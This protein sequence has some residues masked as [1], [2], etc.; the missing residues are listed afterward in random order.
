MIIVSRVVGGFRQANF[1]VGF[2][3]TPF[4]L[5]SSK[6]S[7]KKQ[8]AILAHIA[9]ELF[10]SLK[11]KSPLRVALVG[12]K[13]K[14][15]TVW[16]AYREGAIDKT[17]EK[18]ITL[19]LHQLPPVSDVSFTSTMDLFP[20][21]SYISATAHNAQI[22]STSY[23]TRYQKAFESGQVAP[24]ALPDYPS[25][26]AALN[27]N[28][29][30]IPDY[31]G[32]SEP[33]AI[34]R[35]LSKLI[36]DRQFKLQVLKDALDVVDADHPAKGS[37]EKFIAVEDGYLSAHLNMEYVFGE[38][39][40]KQ[41]IYHAL[42]AEGM[43]DFSVSM[44]KVALNRAAV[45][46]YN[47][48][49]LL[50]AP[51]KNAAEFNGIFQPMGLAIVGGRLLT[52]ELYEKEFSNEE[53]QAAIHSLLIRCNSLQWVDS[54]AMT[55]Y[56][57][58]VIEK[59]LDQAFKAASA[60]MDQDCPF[61]INVSSPPGWF[62]GWEQP[63][64]SFNS[65]VKNSRAY[66]TDGDV[67]ALNGL[68]DILSLSSDKAE[69]EKPW[70]PRINEVIASISSLHSKEDALNLPEPPASPFSVMSSVSSSNN[71][72]ASTSTIL[73]EASRNPSLNHSMDDL[74]STKIKGS[75]MK[76]S[77]EMDGKGADDESLASEQPI[78]GAAS[79][80]SSEAPPPPRPKRR[81]R[82]VA[83]IL[84]PSSSQ[85]GQVQ[86]AIANDPQ[87]VMDDAVIENLTEK[88]CHDLVEQIKATIWSTT[89][90]TKNIFGVA[91]FA[92]LSMG[93]SLKDLPK[94]I[95]AIYIQVTR[96]CQAERVTDTEKLEFARIIARD[97]YNLKTKRRLASTDRAYNV[98]SRALSKK[99]F[100]EKEAAYEC[101]GNRTKIETLKAIMDYIEKTKWR[102][103]YLYPC[104]SRLPDDE[105]NRNVLQLPKHVAKQY[106]CLK[107]FFM[108]KHR[109]PYAEE[110]RVLN[111]VQKIALDAVHN[112]QKK[113]RDYRTTQFYQILSGPKQKMQQKLESF[114]AEIV[115]KSSKSHEVLEDLKNW[116]ETSVWYVQGGLFA[117]DRRHLNNFSMTHLRP[118]NGTAPKGCVNDLPTNV[119]AQYKLI[120][121]YF[122]DI[123]SS[124]AVDA[125][126][127][128]NAVQVIAQKVNN[129]GLG[130]RARQTEQ[131]YDAFKN[132]NSLD[133]L[134]GKLDNLRVINNRQ[135]N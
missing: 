122:S 87:R 65:C 82:R 104:E 64:F 131:Y 11:D 19:D 29:G 39:N 58:H 1:E 26:E 46:F 8:Q 22:V 86:V 121:A 108:Q 71:L 84:E 43:R 38:K 25:L 55:V 77:T 118:E 94:H 134:Q 113:T 51:K 115:A 53:W 68:A 101:N 111:A 99:A 2:N 67:D 110:S 45:N 14:E 57:R 95:R 13:N 62:R 48:Y 92:N 21:I 28:L 120:V 97:A 90:V 114:K 49:V 66:F 128:L 15:I 27:I 126:K 133:E 127:V 74:L 44:L 33:Q 4:E 6:L 109:D 102:G 76:F 119:R 72:T 36:S 41:R 80:H 81:K 85:S 125:I 83:T 18:I 78:A 42:S 56:G 34:Y 5:V 50:S 89:W 100:F 31:R 130:R 16:C 96:D 123:A 117:R 116:I 9:S 124:K 69:G 73:S 47:Q 23:H 12:Y 105:G 3:D 88:E 106:A 61:A 37:V 79:S 107:A 7:P 129:K 54:Q 112:S 40:K 10:P 30:E 59:E 63:S 98:L 20:E 103:A 91:S 35:R 52:N 24:L 75:E 60:V 132:A 135:P 17:E 70:E 93:A 32:S